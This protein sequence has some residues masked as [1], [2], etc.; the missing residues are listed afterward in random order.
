MQ[1]YGLAA[2]VA[3]PLTV[4]GR[5]V[6]V[7]GIGFAEVQH[8][9][10]VERA[11]LLAVA[12][13]C[14]QA[15]D[16]RDSPRP[17]VGDR[18][19]PAARP[20]ARPAPGRPRLAQAARYLRGRQGHRGR[21]RLVRRHHLDD[22]YVRSPSVTSS[23][24]GS[25]RRGDH[26]AAAQRV[27][28]ALPAGEPLPVATAVEPGCPASPPSSPV[29]GPDGRRAWSWT[30]R[31]G[32]RALGAARDTAARCSWIPDGQ[33]RFL[34][35]D[36]SGTVLGALGGRPQIT[37]G[38]DVL[39]PGPTLLLYTDGL[40]E[41]RGELLD[42]G[43]ARA[44]DVA[45]RQGCRPTGAPDR[46]GCCAA[47]RRRP[48]GPTT[49]RSSPPGCCPAR[50]RPAPT[51]PCPLGSPACAVW[52]RM[53]DGGGAA[54][55]DRRRSPAGARGGAGQRR[56]ARLLGWWS[57]GVRVPRGPG[58]RRLRGRRGGRHRHVAAPAGRPRLPRP[59]AGAHLGVGPG[60]R[61]HPRARWCG[62][63]RHP[64]AVPVPR[65]HG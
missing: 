43:L 10:A 12:E 22:D 38:D 34:D 53:G 15:L 14:A 42:D 11:M 40:V 57:G 23:G 45:V 62:R 25:A 3:L 29:R 32:M 39:A 18:R 6:G 1:A 48:A 27:V 13:Q 47:S 65:R 16:R 19:H 20:A 21:R 63:G 36:A 24:R 4:A 5:V 52:Y 37:E 26:G 59:R 54:L 28:T 61:A 64:G 35:G 31:C 44:L 30:D 55:G 7:I 46:A 17:A 33:C 50:C 56:R 58:G 8:F 49:S 41:R 9:P 60:R 2:N 51:R